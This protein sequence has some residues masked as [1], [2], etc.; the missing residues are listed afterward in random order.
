MTE[1]ELNEQ[2]DV[3]KKITFKDED[4]FYELSSFIRNLIR[5][6]KEGH[7]Q[8]QWSYCPNLKFID[9]K[10]QRKGIKGESTF[11]KRKS[12]TMKELNYLR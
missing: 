1:I 5:L 3:L 9:D 4:S 2:R 12:E 10:L 8:S 11:Q 7:V 6:I